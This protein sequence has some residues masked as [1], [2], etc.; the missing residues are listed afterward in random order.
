MSTFFSFPSLSFFTL[1]LQPGRARTAPKPK[2]KASRELR[3]R[4]MRMLPSF[5]CD[6][7]RA[8]DPGAALGDVGDIDWEP[9]MARARALHSPLL[10]IRY[11]RPIKSS[12][13]ILKWIKGRF[14][15]FARRDTFEPAQDFTLQA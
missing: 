4:S 9:A 12:T 14:I 8:I 5:L 2:I 1:T 3:F 15:S 11:L 13:K 10:S 7:S 6:L